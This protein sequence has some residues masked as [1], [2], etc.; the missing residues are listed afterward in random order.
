M[1]EVERALEWLF[2][3]SAR[4]GNEGDSVEVHAFVRAV[5]AKYGRRFNTEKWKETVDRYEGR[6]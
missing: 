6:Y 4:Y 1:I 3:E 2:E 5:F